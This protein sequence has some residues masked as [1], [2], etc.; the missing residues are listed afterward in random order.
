MSLEYQIEEPPQVSIAPLDV[1]QR[2][3]YKNERKKFISRQLYNIMEYILTCSFCFLC[4]YIVALLA[5]LGHSCMT[6]LLIW[7]L[8]YASRVLRLSLNL[9]NKLE[10]EKLKHVIFMVVKNCFYIIS[11]AGIL[12][13]YYSNATRI[14]NA[15]LFFLNLSAIIPLIGYTMPKNN[16]FS[17]MRW[18]K[19]LLSL[20]R[21]ITITLALLSY[22]SIYKI[23]IATACM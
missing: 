1:E 18:M 21:S 19:I 22:R 10:K 11:Y 17:F 20:I 6:C 5:N 7:V 15:V 23:T 9:K 12:I 2:R 8:F 3:Q 4:G 16:C 13:H 14:L